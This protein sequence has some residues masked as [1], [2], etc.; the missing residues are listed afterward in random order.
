MIKWEIAFS[1]CLFIPGIMTPAFCLKHL[2]LSYNQTLKFLPGSAQ[3]VTL[4][5]IY[6]T[7]K[8]LLSWRLIKKLKFFHLLNKHRLNI[9][10]ELT[11]LI[12]LVTI[13]TLRLKY[14]WENW[15]IEKWSTLFIVAELIIDSFI[16]CCYIRI[17]EPGYFMKKWN[18]P[19]ITKAKKSM[20]EGLESGRCLFSES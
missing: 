14:R 15:G 13:F 9:Y 8:Q 16:W 2:K 10:Q 18:T 5:H 7:Y 4:F 6:D 19:P 3:F 20:F 17:R 11:Q 1:G 12:T